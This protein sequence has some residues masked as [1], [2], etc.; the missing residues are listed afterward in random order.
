MQQSLHGEPRNRVAQGSVRKAQSDWGGFRRK[1]AFLPFISAFLPVLVAAGSERPLA[2]ERLPAT[3]LMVYRT[4]DERLGTVKTSSQW[5]QRR[6][7]LLQGM[8]AI[9]GPLPGPE[10]RC[11]LDVQVSA[12]TDAGSYVV[13]ALTYASEPGSRVPADLL[14]PKTVFGSRR[15]FPAVL[16]LHPTDMQFGRRVLLEQLRENYRAYGRD[17]AERG[18]VVLAPA[19]PLMAD[20]QPDLKSLGYQSGT[21]K[22]V[23]DN[24]R[25]I[26]LL[27]TLPFVDKK[28]IGAI[29]HSL[30][31]HNAIFTA[32]FDSRIKAVVSS[33]GFDSF[34]DYMDG[35]ITGWTSER[36]MPR[37][38]TYAARL[39][40]I[41]FDFPELLGALAPRHVF[42]SAPLG[43]TNFRWRSV[44]R[45]AAAAMPVFRLYRVP[46]NLVIQHPDCGHDLPPEIREQAY[47]FLRD[48]LR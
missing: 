22:A 26:D 25:A 33:C 29:G 21:M 6:R 14:I 16:A 2:P 11:P 32:V 17:L 19:Y 12:E 41:P 13:R 43:D 36:Y 47:Q 4:K 24:Q 1:A 46:Q 38:A 28:R 48:T 27:E 34:V 44:D 35:R 9:M 37:L 31:G 5:L 42:V 18:F 30:G 39:D 20:Y 10:R 7:E 15:S 8:E 45:I 3:N 23:W 40:Q